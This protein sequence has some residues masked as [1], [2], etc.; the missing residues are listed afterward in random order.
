MVH[1]SLSSLGRCCG[2]HSNN[3]VIDGISCVFAASYCFAQRL[4]FLFMYPPVIYYRDDCSQFGHTLMVCLHCSTFRPIPRQIKYG[5]C[6]IVWRC[7]Y[8]TET[9]GNTIPIGFCVHI[10][11]ISLWQC[12][13]TISRIM[14]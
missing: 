7:S 14:R 11:G 13:C 3:L 12:E 2:S 1:I 6:G 10:L 4:K 9:E 5:L 8:C